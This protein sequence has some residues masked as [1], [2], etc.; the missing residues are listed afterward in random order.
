MP[1]RILKEV[2][3]YEVSLLNTGFGMNE[4]AGVDNYKGT[5][6]EEFEIDTRIKVI[7]DKEHE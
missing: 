2:K 3:V 4:L 6:L 1:T 5:R 7:E